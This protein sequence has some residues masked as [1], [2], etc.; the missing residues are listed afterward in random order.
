MR[1]HCLDQGHLL[2]ARAALDL[3]FARDRFIHAFIGLVEHQQ[4]API[5]ARETLPEALAVLVD[6]LRQVR[7]DAGVERAVAVAG[8]DVDAGR[9]GHGKFRTA[10]G[11]R[12]QDCTKARARQPAK[13]QVQQPLDCFVARAPRN[14]GDVIGEFDRVDVSA[15]RGG[16]FIAGQP[17]AEF[18]EDVAPGKDARAA[19]AMLATPSL[20]GALATKQSRGGGTCGARGPQTA[21]MRPLDC[22]VASLLAMTGERS[23]TQSPHRGRAIAGSLPRSGP[24]SWRAS[25]P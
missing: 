24:S 15:R 16:R 6:A 18:P 13:R 9:A 2:G 21:V 8:H 19:P 17:H 7:R 25:R 1:V 14:D 20:R 5:A 22:F 4:L 11:E 10:I 23:L 12:R 3:L